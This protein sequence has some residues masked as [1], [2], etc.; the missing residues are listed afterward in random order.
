[1]KSVSESRRNERFRWRAMAIGWVAGAG[2]LF[3]LWLNCHGA[4]LDDIQKRGVLI[5]LGIPYAN[6]VTGGGDGLDV[7]LMQRF[8][9]HLGVGYQYVSSNWADIIPDL[10]G[11]RFSFEGESVHIVAEAPVKGDV[12][13]NGMTILPQRE[14]VLSFGTPTFPTQVWLIARHDS[15]LA[16]ISP[17]GDTEHDIASVKSLLRG[18]EVM[19]IPDTCLEPELYRLE[20]TGA[21]IRNFSGKLNEL[22]PAVIQGEAELTL[23]DVPDSFVALEKWPGKLKVIGPIS[24]VQEMSCAFPKES[25]KLRELFNLFFEQIKKDGSYLRLVRKYYPTA[26]A[27]FPEFFSD[28][29]EK[30]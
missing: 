20:E 13:A 21:R 9:Q 6:F 28:F 16:P 12:I 3:A 19:G 27:H 26:S 15:S 4:D 10:V 30:P 25:I 11:K 18:H 8:A 5:H 7:E 29:H 22:A 1:M 17:S 23:L 24:P 14:R 2:L